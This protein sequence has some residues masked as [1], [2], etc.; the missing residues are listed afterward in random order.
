MVWADLFITA[1]CAV[2]GRRRCNNLECNY[3]SLRETQPLIGKRCPT[4]L[5]SLSIVRVDISIT[6]LQTAGTTAPTQTTLSTRICSGGSSFAHESAYLLR[7]QVFASSSKF[8]GCTSI[9]YSTRDTVSL[10][11]RSTWLSM[12]TSCVPSTPGGAQKVT[13]LRDNS[14]LKGH[15]RQVLLETFS[16]VHAG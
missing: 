14:F 2:Q 8:A 4:L 1:R 12:S 6:N 5:W 7:R 11:L 10:L 3:C 15:P 13:T 16:D 9:G